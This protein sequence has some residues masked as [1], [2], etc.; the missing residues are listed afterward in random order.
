MKGLILSGG[1]GSPYLQFGLYTYEK[2]SPISQ[3][4]VHILQDC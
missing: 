3:Q 1:P 2:T 4:F